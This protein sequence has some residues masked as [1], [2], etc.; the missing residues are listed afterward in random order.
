MNN[1]YNLIFNKLS[2][3][4]FKSSYSSYF[5]HNPENEVTDSIL[6]DMFKHFKSK[7]EWKKVVKI[8]TLRVKIKYYDKIK[9]LSR[10]NS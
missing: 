6:M 7:K 3:E 5:M 4:D 10:I 9:R 1:S 8:T 2:I